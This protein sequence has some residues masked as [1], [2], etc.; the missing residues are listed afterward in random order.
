L[1]YIF[2]KGHNCES[3]MVFGLVKSTKLHKE[4]VDLCLQKAKIF[5]Q[6]KPFLLHLPKVRLRQRCYCNVTFVEV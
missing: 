5:R 4:H 1:T 6:L 2:E 3:L